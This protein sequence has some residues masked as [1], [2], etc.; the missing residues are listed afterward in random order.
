MDI[1]AICSKCRSDKLAMPKLGDK[2]QMVR[3]LNC[4]SDVGEKSAMDRQLKAAAQKQAD[5]MKANLKKSLS[6]LGFK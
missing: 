1:K 4:G 5:K 6:K 2:D 3:C